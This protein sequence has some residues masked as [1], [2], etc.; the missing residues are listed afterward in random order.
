MRQRADLT[1]QTFGR[2]TALSM[3]YPLE[4]STKWVCSCECGSQA[5]VEIR[6]L[7]NGHTRSCGCLKLDLQTSHG[8]TGTD[9]YSRWR[10]MLDRCHQPENRSY[11]RYGARGI[12]VCDRWRFGADGLS[13]VE[14]Y[15]KDMGDRPSKRHSVDRIDNDGPY[16]PDN[17]RWA[18][19]REQALNRR[20]TLKPDDLAKLR[21]MIEGGMS[22]TE[23]ADSLGVPKTTIE[24]RWLKVR[25][26]LGVNGYWARRP[27]KPG[28]IG[29]YHIW[30]TL[31]QKAA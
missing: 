8:L 10:T 6:K 14:C 11:H 27:N 7:R 12:T 26:E 30:V 16:S 23:V 19:R 20:D 28:H 2:L 24:R 5:V 13:G 18:T 21:E 9:A 25:R 17:C 1:G 4:R 15:I 31:D 3:V 29:A 22:M